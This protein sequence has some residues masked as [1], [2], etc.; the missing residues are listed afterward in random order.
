MVSRI[1]RPGIPS[2]GTPRALRNAALRVPNS[3]HYRHPNPCRML[4][5]PAFAWQALKIAL[6]KHTS[7]RLS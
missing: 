2:K 5:R 4:A 3:M 6:P 1:L 7:S